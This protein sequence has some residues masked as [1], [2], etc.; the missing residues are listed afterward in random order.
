MLCQKLQGKVVSKNISVNVFWDL[1]SNDIL[2]NLGEACLFKEVLKFYPEEE[3]KCFKREAEYCHPG[4]AY[5]LS[6]C[7]IRWVLW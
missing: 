2:E 7:F 1:M 6:G 5:M 4:A 3:A